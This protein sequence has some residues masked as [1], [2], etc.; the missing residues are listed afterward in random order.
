[1]RGNLIVAIVGILCLIAL[2]ATIV[3]VNT[4]EV[5]PYPVLAPIVA[6]NSFVYIIGIFGYVY[7][8]FIELPEYYGMG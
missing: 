5:S 3:T 7:F 4:L 6:I 1:M 2:G 8:R